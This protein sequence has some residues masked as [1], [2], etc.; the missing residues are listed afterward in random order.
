[1]GSITLTLREEHLLK[2]RELA[3]GAGMTPEEWLQSRIE[4]ML[5]QPESDFERAAKYVL[6][7]NQELYRRLA[8]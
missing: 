5:A 1:M 6:D 4:A 8:L 7:K 3:R 2:I